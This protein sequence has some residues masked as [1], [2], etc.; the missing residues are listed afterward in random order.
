MKQPPKP[1]KAP[2]TIE[3]PENA[4]IRRH[5]FLENYVILAPKRNLRPDSFSHPN[6]PHKLP[7]ATCPF[8]HKQEAIV[9]QLPHGKDWRVK[10]IRNA[11][12]ALT[13]ENTQAFGAQEVVINTPDHALEFS[14]LPV[15]H[16]EEVFEAYRHRLIHLKQIEGIRY[17]LVFKNDGP[18]AG[19]SVPHAHCQIFGL[20]LVPPKII[21]ESDALNHYWDEHQS[22][23]YCDIVAWEVRQKARIIFED[24][25]FIA[26][27]PHAASY[28]FE[29]WLIP[30]RHETQFANLN[31]SELHSLAVILKK[32]TAKL[33]T[34]VIS[35]NYFLQESLSNQNHHFVLKVEPRTTKWA[36]AELGT[37]VIINPVTPEYAALWY[38]GKV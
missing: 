4:E 35:F 29:V 20:P 27:S 33:D 21:Q 36:G 3:V 37:G 2:Q 38:Q 30:R 9:W 13:L 34:N 28:A 16:I 15:D 5:Y 23:A 11:F 1:K 12:P 24:K 14:D 18:M 26:L 25:H 17:V 32:I 19:A 10:V 8:C 7:G 6:E 22:C 31:G